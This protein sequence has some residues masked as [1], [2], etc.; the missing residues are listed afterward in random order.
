MLSCLP[1][2]KS[3][4]AGEGFLAQAPDGS[5]YHFDWMVVTPVEPFAKPKIELGQVV[6]TGNARKITY[7]DGLLRPVIT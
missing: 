4:H 1:T 6:A 7:F 3:R 5:K 2:L